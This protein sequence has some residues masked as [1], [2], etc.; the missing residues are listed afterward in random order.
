[1]NATVDTVFEYQVPALMAT[2]LTIRMFAPRQY[3]PLAATA[4]GVLQ[5]FRLLPSILVT[6]FKPR[7]HAFKVTPKGSAADSTLSEDWPT[8]SIACGLML[9]T[10]I[11]LVLNGTFNLQIVGSGTLIPVVAFWALFNM[12]VL[13]VVCTIAVS[14]PRLRSEERFAMDEP[15]RL[16]MDRDGVAAALVRDLSLSGALIE[17]DADSPK[18]Q[19]ESWN[20]GDW[21]LLQ[22][23]GVAPIAACV[24]RVMQGRD[25]SVRAGLALHLPPS[26]T[27][28]ALIRKLF[29]Q[30]IEQPELRSQPFRVTLLLLLRV[31]KPDRVDRIISTPSAPPPTWIEEYLAPSGIASG[32]APRAGCHG[33]EQIDAA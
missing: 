29:T 1:M 25:G 3:F 10:A 17:S 23:A 33:S 12:L 2:I 11:G 15:C 27:R 31:L 26:D 32:A 19:G 9:A 7:G 4:H 21:L 16:I 22:V 20:P 8:I 6:V 13:A 5:A 18:F 24:R 30:G 14:P 28:N